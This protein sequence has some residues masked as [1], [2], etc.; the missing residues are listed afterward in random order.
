MAAQ[1]SATIAEGMYKTVDPMIEDGRWGAAWIVTVLYRQVLHPIFFYRSLASTSTTYSFQSHSNLSCKHPHHSLKL[2]Q[3]ADTHTH[4]RS[5]I[6]ESS[7]SPSFLPS[8][9][10]ALQHSV[11]FILISVLVVIFI[12]PAAASS[13]IPETMAF[14][15]GVRGFFSPPITVQ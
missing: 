8:P 13:G 14:L 12:E 7:F 1:T 15:N 6:H 10:S 9:T 11:F 3:Y 5:H 2:H 4:S